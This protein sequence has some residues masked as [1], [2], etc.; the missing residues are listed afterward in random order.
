MGIKQGLPDDQKMKSLLQILS[1][2][3]SK[4]WLLAANSRILVGYWINVS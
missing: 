3:S 1:S 2:G 4:S